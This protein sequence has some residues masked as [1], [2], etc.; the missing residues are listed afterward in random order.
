VIFTLGGIG[1][2]CCNADPDPTTCSSSPT[3]RLA[4]LDYGATRTVSRERA[5][6]GLALVEAFAAG[7]AEALGDA[8]RAVGSASADQAHGRWS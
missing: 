3:A 7:D 1:P 4:V 2:A 6:L 8:L 5:D